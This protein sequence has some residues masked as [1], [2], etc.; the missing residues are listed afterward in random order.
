MKD[1]KRAGEREKGERKSKRTE[2]SMPMHY[3]RVRLHHEHLY[4]LGD[5]VLNRSVHEWIRT[6]AEILVCGCVCLCLS[7]YS[8]F[9][10]IFTSL[11]TSTCFGPRTII[12]ENCSD[13]STFA[14]T[15]HITPHFEKSLYE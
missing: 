8:I 1:H 12:I 6:M 13:R 14:P 4:G 2:M 15:S 10:D 5:D 3:A 7:N 9:G 11:N